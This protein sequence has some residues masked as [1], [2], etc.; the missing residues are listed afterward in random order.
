MDVDTVLGYKPMLYGI[1]SVYAFAGVGFMIGPSPIMLSVLE[2][3]QYAIWACLII[4]GGALGAIGAMTGR[5]YTEGVGLISL[6]G[7][8]FVYAVA[9]TFIEGPIGAAPL[10]LPLLILSS[11]GTLCVRGVVVRHQIKIRQRLSEV[12]RRESH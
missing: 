11:I 1:Y 2:P 7:G 3:L 10:G 12:I 6:I 9:L 8:L 4:F 5:H